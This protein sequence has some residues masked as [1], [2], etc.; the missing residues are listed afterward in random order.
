VPINMPDDGR[1]PC[2]PWSKDYKKNLTILEKIP[3][4]IVA[5]SWNGGE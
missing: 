1:L 5:V 4:P 2:I 3:M